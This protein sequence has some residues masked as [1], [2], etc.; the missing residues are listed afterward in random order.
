MGLYLVDT[1]PACKTGLP[2]N[3]LSSEGY[4][5]CLHSFEGFFS[6]VRCIFMHWWSGGV[7]ACVFVLGFRCSVVRGNRALSFFPRFS[8]FYNWLDFDGL[9]DHGFCIALVCEPS[10]FSEQ[11]W[12]LVSGAAS[13]LVFLILRAFME[14]CLGFPS[15]CRI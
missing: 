1:P 6:L 5:L 12:R 11:S 14:K 8:R 7:C 4:K 15:P 9:L 10:S 2:K 3:S 13:F